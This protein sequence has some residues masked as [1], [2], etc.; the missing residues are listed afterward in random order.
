MSQ[1]ETASVG[2][3]VEEMVKLEYGALRAEEL[4]RENARLQV[5]T[6]FLSLAGAFGVVSVQGGLVAY[7]VVLFPLL[8]LC[9]ARHARHSEDVLRQVR[10]YLYR[11]EK[12]YGYG[13]YEHFSRS[14]VRSSHGGHIM[15][16]RDAFVLT[17]LL[18]VGVVS[19]RL[20]LDHVVL[21]VIVLALVV[22]GVVVVLTWCWLR[23]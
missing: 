12:Q 1:E 5:W 11:L 10:S 13:G 8:V 14:V 2:K 15:A 6:V 18:A 3:M 17:Q 21:V 22:Q 7:V 20:A 16:L 4:A 23:K 9:L 19:V